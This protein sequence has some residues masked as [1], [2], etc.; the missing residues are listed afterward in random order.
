MRSNYIEQYF[1]YA[2]PRPGQLPLI[3][4]IQET[5]SI[6]N[7]LCV[8]AANGFGKTVAALSGVLP[9]LNEMKCGVLYVARTHKQLDRAM[10]E[11]RPISESTGSSGVVLRGRASSCLNPLVRKYATSAQLA[12]FICSQLKRSG[13]CEYY[14]NFIKKTK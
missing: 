13:R 2:K 6:G 11:L 1:P 14:Q 8:E 5:V 9:L 3:K 7:H 12:M 4:A 10:E